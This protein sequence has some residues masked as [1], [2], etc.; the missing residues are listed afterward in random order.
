MR[1]SKVYIDVYYYTDKTT[2]KEYARTVAGIFFDYTDKKFEEIVIT[3][4]DNIAEYESGN[5]Y[6]RELPPI[7]DVLDEI[8]RKGYKLDTI[9][10]DG[11]VHMCEDDGK[12]YHPG[13]GKRLADALVGTN[14]EGIDIVGIAKHHYA[15]L[16]PDT[17]VEYE[18]TPTFI[19]EI[20]ANTKLPKKAMYIT[21][22]TDRTFLYASDIIAMEKVQKG[23]KFSKLFTLVDQE[24]KKFKHD[25]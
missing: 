12:T 23:S 21:S 3:R 13:L 15:F 20:P 9:I 16:H 14:L 6:K 18:G 2:G 4:T 5:F 24:T 8:Y 22:N 25:S 11:Y 17:V 7:L 10:V 1:T 19:G